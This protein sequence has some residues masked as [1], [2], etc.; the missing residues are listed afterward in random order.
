V[1]GV[2]VALLLMAGLVVD[3]GNAINAR[4][5]IADD[6]EQAARAGATAIDQRALR[7]RGVLVLDRPA[8]RRRATDYLVGLGY[9]A[10]DITFPAALPQTTRQLSVS[11]RDVVPTQILTLIGKNDFP[12][13]ASSTARAATGITSEEPAP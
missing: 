11:A 4:Q 1:L 7:D 12:V 3:G 8:A 13:S 2:S 9:S 5:R 6:V 10:G